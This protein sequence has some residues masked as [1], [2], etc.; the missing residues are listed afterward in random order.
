MRRRMLDNRTWIAAMVFIAALGTPAAA[1]AGPTEPV[2]VLAGSSAAAAAA[3]TAAGGSVDRDLPVIGGVAAHL[4]AHLAAPH[5]LASLPGV[6]VVPDAPMHLTAAGFAPTSSTPQFG[7]L[8]TDP[9]WG[10]EAGEGVGVALVDTGVAAVPALAGHVVNAADFSGENDGVDHYGHGTFMAGLIATAA[11]AADIVS[12]KVAGRDGSTSLGQVLAGI[13]WAVEH[14]DEHDLRVL[15]LSF[16]ADLPVAWRAD[17]LSAAV[18]AAWASGITVVTSSG[19]DGPGTVTTPGRDPW[20]LTVGATDVHGTA[21]TADDTV[22][23]FSG[24]GRVPPFGLKPE[25]VAPGVDVV[26]V[27]A[28]GSY[29]DTAYPAARIGDDGFRGSGTSM[30]TALTSGA[31]AVVTW[32]HPDATPDD[33]K[34]ALVAGGDRLAGAWSRAVDVQA[35]V[36]VD[37]DEWDQHLPVA[38]GRDDDER[39]GMPWTVTRWS[40]TR[41]SAT[42]WSATRWS[43]TRWSATRWSATRWS[44]TRW[45]ATRWSATRWSGTRWSGTRWSGTRWSAAEWG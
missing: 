25:V 4:P 44:A 32:A 15:N 34:G 9:A 43:A 37:S 1:A 17:P 22:P 21:S 16:G 6:T 41:W 29:L 28:P 38:G 7:A 36:A 8:H 20:V 40:A 5:S 23:S 39:T 12:I 45:S 10:D 26:S 31:A 35:A 14:A 11:P 19:N 13:D 3:V 42:R 2:V 33:V 18:E 30:A 24:S 27:R